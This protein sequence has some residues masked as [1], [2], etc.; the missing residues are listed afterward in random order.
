MSIIDY[1]TSWKSPGNVLEN[2]IYLAMGTM[3]LMT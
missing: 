3:Y 1:T 2:N